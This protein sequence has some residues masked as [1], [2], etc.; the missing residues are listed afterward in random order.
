M[1]RLGVVA[2]AAAAAVAVTA[3]SASAHHCFVPMYSLD[4]PSSSNWFVVSAEEGAALIAGYEAECDEAAD[5]GYAALKAARLPVGI[6][7]FEKMTIGDPKATERIPNP[8]GANGKGLEYFGAG[9]TL[10]DEM[11]ETWIAGASAHEC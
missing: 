3:T 7:I 2:A 4:G 11:L 10:A 1:R 9:S 8:N 6:K 5:A